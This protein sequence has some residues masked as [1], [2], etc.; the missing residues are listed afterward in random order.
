MKEALFRYID[1]NK[2]AL[3]ETLSALI[4]IDT[5]NDGTHGRE[6]AL[7]EYLR[8]EFAKLGLAGELYSPDEVPGLVDHPDYLPGRNLADR[9]N[10]TVKL[11]G[12]EGR[13]A[14]MLAGH[15]DTV[16]IGDPALWTVPPTGGLIRD[17]RVY[18]R[19]ANDDKFAFAVFLFLTGA[20]RK[21]GL[22]L[23]N[24]L[25]LTGYVD[26]EFGGGD[27]A[28]ACTVKYPCDFYINLDSDALDIFPC[29]VGGQRLYITLRALTPQN[30]CEAVIEGMYL[31][32]KA[33]DVF[34]ARRRAELAEEPIFAGTGIP[35]DALRY[36]NISSGLN[37]NDRHIG[38]LDFA[39]YTDREESEI[40]GELDALFAEIGEKIAPLGL[41]IDKIGYRSRFF[42]YTGT[43]G[44]D[45]EILRLR[46]AVAAVTGR[47]PR[48]IG[49][50]LSD[51]SLF[52]RNSGGRA[53]SF[54]V[55]R[56][57]GLY[58]GAHQPDEFAD[59]GELVA[60][61]KILVEYISDWDE[62]K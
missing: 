6:R 43:D 53:V 25:Y 28:L 31:A 35:G 3:F 21:L 60:L 29:A 10:I 24:D 45:P 37:T 14:L 11:P 19:G 48:V 58:G 39:F 4:R 34:G 5:E 15:L 44:D 59:C 16:P 23:K 8:D 32:K 62:A 7:A 40:R 38:V 22:R 1:E 50:C 51:L 41:V 13:R 49:S 61:T 47:E 42:R 54:G 9:P 57:F 2:E 20:M 12:T 56:D 30:S 27:G 33:I 46:C 36:M 52:L 26:E 18:G 17:G 55:G